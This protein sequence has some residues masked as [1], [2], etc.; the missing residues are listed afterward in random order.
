M[1][2]SRNLSYLV[3][4]WLQCSCT[5]NRSLCKCVPFIWF[6]VELTGLDCLNELVSCKIK[7]LCENM[8]MKLTRMDTWASWQTFMMKNSAKHRDTEQRS[9]CRTAPCPVCVSLLSG[10][11]CEKVKMKNFDFCILAYFF[12]CKN[13][14]RNAFRTRLLSS[15]SVG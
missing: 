13:C 11:K 9:T 1:T 14:G 12:F 6:R 4:L 10:N 8:N 2:F 15:Q 5:L 3:S 7:I